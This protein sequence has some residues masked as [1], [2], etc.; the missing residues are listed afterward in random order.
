MLRTKIA[1]LQKNASLKLSKVIY[2]TY[3]HLCTKNLGNQLVVLQYASLQASKYILQSIQNQL[4][5]SKI[6]KKTKPSPF[7]FVSS[8][9]NV[10]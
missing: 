2:T 9:E 6:S 5:N 7:Y 8:I 4:F 1:F 3:A 10:P